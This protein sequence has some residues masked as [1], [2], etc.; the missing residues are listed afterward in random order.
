MQHKKRLIEVNVKCRHLKIDLSRQVSEYICRLEVANFLLTCSHISCLYLQ[1]IFV[2]CTRPYCL[3]P[4]LSGSSPPPPSLC[5]KVS[6]IYVFSVCGGGVI[7]SFGDHILQKFYT[8]YINKFRIKNLI[9]HPTQKIQE[10]R[11]PQTDQHPL[12]VNLF[13]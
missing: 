7:G 8:L 4:L 12:K 2:T 3:S 9:D 6:F 13:R 5:E 1:R 11:G 10:G